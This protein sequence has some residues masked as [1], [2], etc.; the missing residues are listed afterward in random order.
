M[1]WRGVAVSGRG[2]AAVEVARRSPGPGAELPGGL[3]AANK[4]LERTAVTPGRHP[5]RHQNSAIIG[6]LVL[7]AAVVRVIPFPEGSWRAQGGSSRP[8][9]ER[10]ATAETLS[11]PAL[12]A[13][14][15]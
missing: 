12:P 11:S 4:L 15:G 9:A 2:G 13:A 1:C 6:P 7:P 10:V 3:A 8:F 14:A 5:L